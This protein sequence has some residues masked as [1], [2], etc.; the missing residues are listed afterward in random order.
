LLNKTTVLLQDFF[1][2]NVHPC[3]HIVPQIFRN[4]ETQINPL[5]SINVV[6]F[7]MSSFIFREAPQ[8]ESAG[9]SMTAVKW[10]DVSTVFALWKMVRHTV[11]RFDEG[12]QGPH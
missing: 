8:E 1:K 12:N 7:L 4:S 5:S 3:N 10:P 2:T 6:G 9:L 11:Q